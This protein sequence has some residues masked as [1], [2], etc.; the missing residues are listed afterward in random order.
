L[1]V[2]EAD[3]VPV[4]LRSRCFKW[5]HMPCGDDFWCLEEGIPEVSTKAVLG[6]GERSSWSW[7]G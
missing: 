1:S 2:L 7:A 6:R 3:S 5:Q 4:S